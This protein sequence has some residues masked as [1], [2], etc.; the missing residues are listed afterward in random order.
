MNILEIFLGQIPEAIYF[1]LFL[2]GVLSLKKNRL[3]FTAILIIE[4][5]LLMAVFPY[6][7]WSHII[8]FIITYGVLQVIYKVESNITAVFTLGIASIILMITNIAVYFIV[9]WLFNNFL[10]YAI[11]HRLLLFG[12]LFIFWK[13]L[14]LLQNMYNKLW[15]R[16][17]KVKYKMKSATFRSINVVV[18][19]I[20][21]YIINICMVLH[22]YLNGGV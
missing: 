9:W 6:S 7:I 18:F 5:V 21:F 17:D 3:L 15:N 16:N 11:L 10:V 1:S 14:P 19:N 2:I 22:M 8:F 4:Y 13:K 12:L 20:M